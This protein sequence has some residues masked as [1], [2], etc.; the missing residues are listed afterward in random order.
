MRADHY[1]IIFSDSPEL[2]PLRADILHSE[3][4]EARLEYWKDRLR[5][6]LHS[7]RELYIKK[8]HYPSLDEIE[9]DIAH[10]QKLT[11]QELPESVQA[12]RDLRSVFFM[13]G[14]DREN[15]DNLKSLENTV[16][17][18]PAFMSVSLGDSGYWGKTAK[19]ADYPYTLHLDLPAGTR[20]LC[21]AFNEMY[22]AILAPG[23]PYRITK[24]TVNPDGTADLYGVV[25]PR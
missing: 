23:T 15:P 8:G 3:S 7:M 20:G 21:A 1:S 14:F 4:M 18:E 13:E 10:L 16:Q 22:E 25:L 19:G 6:R 9:A 24:V 11:D 5:G 2:Q 12:S 17:V